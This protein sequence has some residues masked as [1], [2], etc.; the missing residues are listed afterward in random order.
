MLIIEV[1]IAL[2]ALILNMVTGNKN[3]EEN[4]EQIKE[5]LRNGKAYEKFKTMVA[6]QY[7]SLEYVEHPEK[8]KKAKYIMPVYAT[9]SGF[10]EKID[11]DIV[12][13]IARY[14]GAGRMNNE[15]EIN[16]TA[17]IV[18]N[19]K[20]GDVVTSGEILAYI[21]TDEEAKVSG[22]TQNLKDAFKYTKKKVPIKS[23]VLEIIQ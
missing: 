18:L 2:G 22:A 3:K 20:I 10:V 6:S 4:A 21:H 16:R 12:G 17:G 7:G 23:R 9:D 14:L 8:M 5:V 1:V 13:S 15:N 11:A 19:K